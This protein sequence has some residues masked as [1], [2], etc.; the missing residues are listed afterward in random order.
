MSSG[1]YGVNVSYTNLGRVHIKIELMADSHED[2]LETAQN[3]LNVQKT[4]FKKHKKDAEEEHK[5]YKKLLRFG[6]GHDVV[7]PPKK[8]DQQ[9]SGG[10]P[11]SN[12]GGM[13]LGAAE[14]FVQE[15]VKKAK[16]KAQGDS[17][18]VF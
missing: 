16:S 1:E 5:R 18:G 13:D 3:I 15:E 7:E 6:P 17:K 12:D 8:Q 9:F 4:W 2:A 11:L 10:S 14:K